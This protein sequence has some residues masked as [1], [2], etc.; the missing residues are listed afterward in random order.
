M[1]TIRG[2]GGGA[3]FHYTFNH[4]IFTQPCV[5][6][7]VLERNKIEIR[8]N[9]K[10]FPKML[11]NSLIYA[12]PKNLVKLEINDSKIYKISIVKV[13]KTRLGN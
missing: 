13:K 4:K 6:C 11:S 1:L 2:G 3:M 9:N 7:F 8:E 10:N 5:E 12:V